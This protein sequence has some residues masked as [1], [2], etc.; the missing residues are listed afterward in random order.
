MIP[1]SGRSTAPNITQIAVSTY[2]KSIFDSKMR[3]VIRIIS[4]KDFTGKS[5][6]VRFDNGQYCCHNNIINLHFY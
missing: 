1:F 4:F 5:Y 6:L 2:N 3:Q